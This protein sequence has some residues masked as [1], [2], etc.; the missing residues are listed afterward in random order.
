MFTGLRWEEAAALTWDEVDLQQGLIVLGESRCKNG[1]QHVV[2]L[3]DFAWRLLHSR[4]ITSIC[5]WVF[6][7]AQFT[8]PILCISTACKYVASKSGVVFSAHDLRRSY[9]TMCDELEIPEDVRKRLVNHVLDT[10]NAYV[11]PSP[12][13]L[14]RVTQRVTDA[15]LHY[16]GVSK[17]E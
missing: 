10:H 14:R 8:A 9:V 13:R 2:P 7:N 17:G 4:R 1:N 11:V 5:R 6:P 3:S 16:M 12:E 15:M